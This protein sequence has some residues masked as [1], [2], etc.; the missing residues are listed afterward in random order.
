L[1]VQSRS[2]GTPRTAG[3]GNGGGAECVR[4]ASAASCVA[5]DTT[6]TSLDELQE[7]LQG[8]ISGEYQAR[9]AQSWDEQQLWM[10][11]IMVLR[12]KVIAAGGTVGMS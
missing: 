1:A 3:V 4:A 10:S 9:I 5:A 7:L 6:P 2:K 12:R 11:R 8:C